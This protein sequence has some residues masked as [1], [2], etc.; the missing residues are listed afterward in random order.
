M[1]DQRAIRAVGQRFKAVRRAFVAT[2]PESRVLI[3]RADGTA[4]Q[5]ALGRGRLAA[6]GAAVVACAL[7]TTTATLMLM[8]QPEELIQREQRLE[9]M[10]SA[11]H[12]AQQR[13]IASQKMVAD[14]TREVDLVQSSLMALAE[15]NAALVK[16]APETQRHAP[17]PAP[18]TDRAQIDDPPAE[19]EVRAVRDQVRRLETSLERLRLAYA[20][21]VQ[22][23][24]DAAT[25]RI[26]D[27]EHSLV[28]LG[29][30]PGRVIQPHR[31]E[32]G[33][34]GPFVPINTMATSEPGLNN[35]LDRLDRWSG[36]KAAM[37]TM[38]LGDPLPAEY[39]VSS[40]FGR[41]NDPLNRRTGVHEGVDLTAP[42]GT[43]VHAT[44]EGQVLFAG[45]WDRYGLA[46]EIDHGGGVTTRYAHLSRILVRE[47]QH[48]S[49]STVIGLLGNTGRS[50][51]PHLHY[52]VRL[53][54]V[55]RDP[56]K[57]IAAGDHALKIW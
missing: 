17:L 9:E 27:A 14:I 43:P 32:R 7:W 33:R 53:S 25:A 36:V 41:R 47:G 20:Q 50:T 11:T 38:P 19:S 10:L 12:T 13:L 3:R 1:G 54:E 46:I 21:A 8:R 23:T 52:E 51:G 56:L 26:A 39:E 49:R 22:S 2:V 16:G 30:D 40:P 45:P 35:L 42:F 37:Q 55:P 57:F 48:V 29:I 34:G 31:P 15:S 18:V 44:G 4:V 24:S 6:L 5:I 28:R